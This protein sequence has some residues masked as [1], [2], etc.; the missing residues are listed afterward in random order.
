M[1][2][3]IYGSFGSVNTLLLMLCVNTLGIGLGLCKALAE[4]GADVVSLQLPSEPDD[5]KVGLGGF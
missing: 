2:S 4:S 3:I 1:K 5:A